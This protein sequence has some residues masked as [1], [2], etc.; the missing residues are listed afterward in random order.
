MLPSGVGNHPVILEFHGFAGTAAEQSDVSGLGALA[1]EAGFAVVVFD[2]Q[3][4]P[5]RSLRWD[6]NGGFDS[7]VAFVDLTMPSLLPCA[8]P[9]FA[10]GFSNGAAFASVL[11]CESE[12][13]VIAVATVSWA[14]E[15]CDNETPL[16]I[17]AFHGTADGTVPF[18]GDGNDVL[19][20]LLGLG[21]GPAEAAIGDWARHNGCTDFTVKQIGPDVQY[22]EWSGCEADTGFYRISNGGHSW[23]G[24][25]SEVQFGVTTRTIAA[26]S[27]IVD[28]F[29]AQLV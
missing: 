7:D 10:T 8:G 26:S 12:L 4:Q 20:F 16:P 6:L 18:D 29:L 9:M 19:E 25:D 3:G 5:G 14:T 15:P 21:S 24:S 28:F 22:T 27:L 2:G 11:G 13:D 17:L 23:P 1:A